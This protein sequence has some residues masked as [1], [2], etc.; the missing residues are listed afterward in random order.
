MWFLWGRRKIGYMKKNMKNKNPLIPDLIGDRLIRE[1]P[2]SIE[3][4]ELI[5]LYGFRITLHLFFLVQ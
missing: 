4:C 3:F 2:C 5:G 1:N